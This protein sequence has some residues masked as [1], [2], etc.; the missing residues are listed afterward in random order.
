MFFVG[1]EMQ[2]DKNGH[3]CGQLVMGSFIT[4]MC[5]LMLHISCRV[6]FGKTSNHPGDS[7]PLQPKLGTLQLLAFPKTKITFE[8]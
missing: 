8:S 3:S 5:P 2:Y 4:T 6:F 1:S 7:D